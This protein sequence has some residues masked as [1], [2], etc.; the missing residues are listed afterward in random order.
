MRTNSRPI[1][2]TSHNGGRLYPPAIAPQ[3]ANFPP[4]RT[5][6]RS[7]RGTAHGRARWHI[8]VHVHHRPP[9][10]ATPR[11]PRGYRKFIFCVVSL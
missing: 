11:M 1:A 9:V 6:R 8:P 2:T 3:A 5:L 7:P 10:C 4:Q